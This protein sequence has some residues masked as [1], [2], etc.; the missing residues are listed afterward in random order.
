[1]GRTT[2]RDVEMGKTTAR[3]V[4]MGRTTARSG[5]Q[6]WGGRR[7]PRVAPVEDSGGRRFF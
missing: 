4:E 7:R 1:M 5:V 3:D 6:R 2:A